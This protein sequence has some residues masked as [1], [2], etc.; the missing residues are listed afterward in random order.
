MQWLTQK[1][2]L[3]TL[4]RR[5]KYYVRL[6]TQFNDWLKVKSTVGPTYYSGAVNGL[7]RVS[8]SRYCQWDF[9]SADR[10]LYEPGNSQK[11]DVLYFA[12]ANQSGANVIAALILKRPVEAM[13]TMFNYRCLWL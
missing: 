2:K 3:V 7:E 5:K 13:D 6:K 10:K 8:V 1:K 9:D 11:R 12:A 4:S